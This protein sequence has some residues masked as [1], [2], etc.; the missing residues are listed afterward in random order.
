M[1]RGM[2]FGIFI[3]SG[4]RILSDEK[5]NVS[6]EWIERHIDESLDNPEAFKVTN[7]PG[8]N[9]PLASNQFAGFITIDKKN[10]GDI[11]YWLFEAS[12]SP[13]TAPLLIWL[14]GG[15]GCSSMDG[16]FLEIGPFKV[17]QDG[18][19]LILN[20]QSW[21]HAANVLFIDQPLGTGLST[22]ENQ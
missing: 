11:F 14:N 7:L 19:T 16:L 8:L 22:V 1:M 12:E 6:S 13:D 2:L 3:V 9:P 20:Q 21:H 17:A 5:Y 4:R 18:K 10:K 15:P